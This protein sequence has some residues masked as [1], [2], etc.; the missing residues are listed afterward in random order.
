MNRNMTCY[1]DGSDEIL[2]VLI[3]Q[4]WNSGAPA[5]LEYW[6]NGVLEY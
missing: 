3:G 5:Q 4:E 1:R 6:S 2:L